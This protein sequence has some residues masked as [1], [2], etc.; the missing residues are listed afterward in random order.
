MQDEKD[1]YQNAIKM[2]QQYQTIINMRN[3]FMQL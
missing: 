1:A 2:M 3:I